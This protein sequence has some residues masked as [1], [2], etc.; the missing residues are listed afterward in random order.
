MGFLEKIIVTP[1]HHRVHHA[2]NK[3]YLDKNLSQIFIFWDK[4]FGTYQEEL[5]DVPPVYGITRPVKTW[6]PVKINFQHLWLMMK[7][8]WRTK[9]WKEKLTLWFKPT[10]YR[11]PDVSEKFPVYKIEDVYRFE[12]FNPRSSGMLAAWCWFQLVM[13]LLFISYLF[14]NISA[15]FNLHPSYIYL[16]GVFIFLGVYALTELMDRNPNAIFWEIFKNLFAIGMIYWQNDWFGAGTWF[17][18]AG[19]FLAVYFI[20]STLVTGWFV[21]KHRSEDALVRQP[22]LL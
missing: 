4:L 20:F 18:P 13:L 16:Y 9:S 17:S 11:P 12:K 6:N 2:I 15:I 5:K 14:G 22:D 7:D 21:I 8:A 1:S 3:E 10:G 19:Y